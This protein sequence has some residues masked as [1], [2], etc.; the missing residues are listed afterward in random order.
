MPTDTA[1]LSRSQ[2]ILSQQVFRRLR[3][4][5]NRRFL[6]GIVVVILVTLAMVAL[7]I[8]NRD[9]QALKSSARVAQGLAKEFQKAFDHD[10]RAPRHLPAIQL[11]NRYIRDVIKFNVN[12]SDQI[13]TSRRVGVFC[14]KHS[15]DM[16]LRFPGRHLVLF[17]GEK[18][19]VEWQTES[20]FQQRAFSLG[21]APHPG[22]ATD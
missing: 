20:E 14:S 19:F 9:T 3:R 21:L 5:R 6:R 12:Y 8:S 18:Y 10:G 7:A 1:T 13:R 2:Q 15:I 16:Y 11:N 22:T 17:D 4:E